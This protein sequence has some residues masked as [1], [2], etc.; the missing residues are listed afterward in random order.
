[1]WL[2]KIRWK[3]EQFVLIFV[4]SFITTLIFASCL[5]FIITVNKFIGNY[6][7]EGR[8]S[9]YFVNTRIEE[10]RDSVEDWAEN[11]DSIE[12]VSTEKGIYISGTIQV[13]DKKLDPNFIYAFPIHNINEMPW[14]MNIVEGNKLAERPEAEEVW[15]SSVFADIHKVTIGD[16]ISVFSSVEEKYTVSAILNNAMC[17]SATLG[18]DYLYLNQDDLNQL[19]DFQQHYLVSVK[20]KGNADYVDNYN[21][22]VNEVGDSIGGVILTKSLLIQVAT[23][24]S[25]IIGGI[26]I[27]SAV[28]IM[29]GANLIIRFILK[30]KLIKEYK[31]IGVYKS[32]GFSSREIRMI[33]IKCFGSIFAVATLLGTIAGNL[34]ANRL[35]DSVLRF[36]GDYRGSTMSFVLSSIIVLSVMNIIAVINFFMVTRRIN[37]LSPVAA[38]SASIEVNDI[39][40]GKSFIRYASNLVTMSLNDIFK[41]RKSSILTLIILT[42]SFYLLI[43]FVNINNSIQGIE[44]NSNLW[45]GTPECNAVISGDFYQRADNN[46]IFNDLDTDPLVSKYIYGEMTSTAHIVLD[47][48]KYSLSNTNI[49][50]TIFNTYEDS[51]FILATG[52]HP[53]KSNEIVV[54]ERIMQEA[55]LRLDDTIV[56]DINGEDIEFIICGTYVTQLNLGYNFRIRIDALGDQQDTY[57]AGELYVVLKDKKDLEQFEQEIEEKYYGF[58]V[59]RIAPATKDTIHTI[60]Q[61]VN[62]VIVMLVIAFIIFALLNIMNLIIMYNLDN[63]KNFGIMKALGYSTMYICLRNLVKIVSLSFVS[64]ALAFLVNSF[65]SKVA[66]KAAVGGIDG[67]LFD[68]LASTLIVSFTLLLIVFIVFL[69]C[70]NIKKIAPKELMEE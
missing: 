42:M 45:F 22:L 23:M 2:K 40:V 37:K 20:N 16:T 44:D 50:V 1:M 58:S 18:I 47:T 53:Q 64:V 43:L 9:D 12:A 27:F 10:V 51:G 68:G 5:G 34:I 36:I 67:M 6:Y 52:K 65:V 3:K 54:S 38:I 35:A 70:I 28:L 60:Q 57:K 30:S 15:I 21:D 55:G 49:G 39:R 13:N 31:S 25:N 4:I 24:I 69:C 63:R 14:K 59:E 7:S 61:I 8:N 48:Q 56:L 11:N 17:P 41:N 46:M 62:P 26:G 66:F 33:Y 32:F 19:T 29:I